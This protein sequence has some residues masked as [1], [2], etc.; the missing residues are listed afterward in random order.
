MYGTNVQIFFFT[1]T[2]KPVQS[3]VGNLSLHMLE[4]KDED[5][6]KVVV[7]FSTGLQK[8]FPLK[9]SNLFPYIYSYASGKYGC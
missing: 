5:R 1:T 7:L 4:C 3:Q 6:P 8:Q 2:F 9:Y